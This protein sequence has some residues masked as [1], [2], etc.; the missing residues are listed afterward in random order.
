MLIPSKRLSSL[1]RRAISPAVSPGLKRIR[2]RALTLIRWVALSV[3]A[4]FV[5]LNVEDVEF[6]DDG[7]RVTIRRLRRGRIMR[8]DAS[9][10]SAG[11]LN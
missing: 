6:T 3:A 5:A 10:Y 11:R 7:L 2:D 9:G 1:S 4:S 8:R